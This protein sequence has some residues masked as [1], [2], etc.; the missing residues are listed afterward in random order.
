MK[1]RKKIIHEN[2]IK[3]YKK[4]DM[5]LPKRISRKTKKL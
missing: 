3:T 2:A 1:P 5:S 4:V